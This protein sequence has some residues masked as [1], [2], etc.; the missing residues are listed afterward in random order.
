MTVKKWI[1]VFVGFL[2]GVGVIVGSYK[3]MEVVQ[4][5]EMNHIVKSEE[6]KEIVENYLK[7]LDEDALT[8]KGKIISYQIDEQSIE[9]NPMGG[10]MFTVFL[11]DDSELYVRMTL[12][13]NHETGKIQRS[14]GGYAKKVKDLVGKKD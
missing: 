1:K 2:V 6:V 12:E 14:G 4:N 10:I 13:K 9:H 11:N 5:N 8:D 3:I 7:Y